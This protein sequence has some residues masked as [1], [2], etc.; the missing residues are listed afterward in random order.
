MNLVKTLPFQLE[1]SVTRFMPAA[2]RTLSVGSLLTFCFRSEINRSPFTYPFKQFFKKFH[3]SSLK[4]LKSQMSAVFTSSSVTR[5][6]VSCLFCRQYPLPKNR[7][8]LTVWRTWSQKVSLQTESRCV[9]SLLVV[10]N[11]KLLVCIQIIEKFRPRCTIEMSSSWLFSPSAFML[12]ANCIRNDFMFLDEDV[13][14]WRV[15]NIPLQDFGRSRC[16]R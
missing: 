13:K 5:K 10:L 1:T 9:S 12:S 16:S 4:P 7:I 3:N 11:H 6:E 8:A 14:W 15:K 2:T